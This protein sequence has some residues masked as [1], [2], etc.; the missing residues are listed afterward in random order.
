MWFSGGDTTLYNYAFLDPINDVDPNGKYAGVDDAAFAIGGAAV[1][2]IGQGLSDL[3]TGQSA[4]WEGYTAA[5]IGGAAGGEA[6]LYTGPV[7][8]GAIGGAVTNLVRQG[9]RQ[10]SGK[11]CSFSATS[12]AIDTGLGAA[13]G[14]IPG[15]RIPGVTAGR[16]SYNSVF[17]QMA[18]K[19]ERDEI[20]TVSSRTA[21]RMFWGRST[22]TALLPGAG[23]G[24]AAGIAVG[25]VLPNQPCGCH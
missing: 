17:R 13:T 6:L 2:L 16:G 9:L 23:A 14:L 7:G 22:D 3:I 25:E 1:G 18:T 4:G 10:A 15:A 21:A 19:F 20:S 8:A 12:F 11:Q 5:A 24:V